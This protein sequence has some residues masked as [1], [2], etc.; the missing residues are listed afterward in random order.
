MTDVTV[1]LNKT[2]LR[3]IIDI[4]SGNHRKLEV[5]LDE[6]IYLSILDTKIHKRLFIHNLSA[7]ST[8]IGRH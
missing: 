1:P 3:K 6:Q 2:G 5:I 8:V 7:V 4:S